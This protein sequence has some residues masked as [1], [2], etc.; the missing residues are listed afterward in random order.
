MTAFWLGLAAFA[1]G[2]VAI[3]VA[4]SRRMPWWARTGMV[5]GG[6]V[7]VAVGLVPLLDFTFGYV[8]VKQVG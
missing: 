8:L 5:F 2:V 6:L 3:F 7:L 4:L 1:A